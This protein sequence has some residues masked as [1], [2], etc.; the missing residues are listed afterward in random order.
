MDRPNSGVGWFV[1]VTP[2]YNYGPSAVLKNAID[3]VYP[4]WKRKAAGFVSYGSAMGA[5]G[6]AA[7]RDGHRASDGA[8]SVVRSHPAGNALGA[9]PGRR[10]GGGTG[11]ARG[12]RKDHDR[13]LAVVDHGAEDRARHGIL[14]SAGPRRRPPWRSL[15]GPRPPCRADRRR[16]PPRRSASYSATERACVR[17][18]ST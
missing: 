1:F 14:I 2:E 17:A 9:F 3:W 4:E 11:R 10:C 15:D 12:V 16:R 7:S 13:R 6:A 5:R 18:S 8:G